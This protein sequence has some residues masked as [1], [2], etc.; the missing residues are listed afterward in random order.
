MDLHF[1]HADQFLIFDLGAKNVD[2]VG[3]RRLS[4]SDDPVPEGVEDLD[5]V[6]DLLS[7]CQ[8]VLSMRAGSHARDRLRNRGISCLEH[9]GLVASGLALVRETLGIA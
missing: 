1:G 5:L 6:V 4:D 8:A 7:D 9:D 3:W 2:Y